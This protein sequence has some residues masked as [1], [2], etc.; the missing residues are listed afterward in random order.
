MSPGLESSGLGMVMF[1][2]NS[3]LNLEMTVPRLPM[4]LEWYSGGTST[5]WNNPVVQ[6]RATLTQAMKMI[7]I[8]SKTLQNAIFFLFLQ[9]FYSIQQSLSCGIYFRC[10]TDNLDDITLLFGRRY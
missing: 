4:I 8:Y 10:R 1:T 9:L 6:S 7:Y 2:W 5:Y 3:S